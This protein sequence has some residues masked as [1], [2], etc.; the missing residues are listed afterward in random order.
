MVEILDDD[1]N[2]RKITDEDINASIENKII[3]V[4]EG[5]GLLENDDIFHYIKG[6]YEITNVPYS[7]IGNFR[8]GSC[9]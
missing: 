5:S 1:N 8:I 2:V 6:K 3:E 4:K 7:S 9:K